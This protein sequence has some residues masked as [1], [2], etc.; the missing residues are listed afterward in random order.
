MQF[1]NYF[2]GGYIGT[3][4]VI[5]IVNN[6]IEAES[7]LLFIAAIILVGNGVLESVREYYSAK[8]GRQ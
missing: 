1:I 8:G 4:G 7:A 3:Q 2:S 6:G 5:G